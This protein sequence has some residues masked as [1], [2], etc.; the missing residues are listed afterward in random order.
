MLKRLHFTV[1]E[2]IKWTDKVSMER[3][4]GVPNLDMI[5]NAER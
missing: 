5:L 3:T 4:Q 2:A 1:G